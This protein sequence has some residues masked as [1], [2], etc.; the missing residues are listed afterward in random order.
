MRAIGRTAKPYALDPIANKPAI[1][2]GADVLARV[3]PAWEDVILKPAPS[4]CKPDDQA[5]AGLRGEFELHWLAGFLLNDR[6][7]V[8]GRSVQNELA[9]AQFNNIAAAQLAGRN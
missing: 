2:P 5:I 9:D 3:N 6:R 7:T 8:T 4:M 1:L